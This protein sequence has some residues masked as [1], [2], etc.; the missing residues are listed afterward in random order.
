MS[1]SCC[2][3]VV[4]ACASHCTRSSSFSKPS[5]GSFM[6]CPNW[7]L[8]CRV[9][10]S[11]TLY[12]TKPRRKKTNGVTE[13]TKPQVNFFQPICLYSFRP[14]V[15]SLPQN[16]KLFYFKKN[17]YN[18]ELLTS[19]YNLWC[20]QLVVFTQHHDKW[21]WLLRMAFCHLVRNF[22]WPTVW[23]SGGI[24]T[25]SE[26]RCVNGMPDRIFKCG[27]CHVQNTDY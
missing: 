1:P 23:I 4:G 18:I 16:L 19:V 3:H 8:S 27:Y 22:V 5:A 6:A 7:C 17:N 12:S 24:I 25:I 10:S 21:Q 14:R 13:W 15:A 26:D 9:P 20:N 11:Y 2:M